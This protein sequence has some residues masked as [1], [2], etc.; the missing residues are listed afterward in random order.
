[1][2]WLI[3]I[4]MFLSAGLYLFFGYRSVAGFIRALAQESRTDLRSVIFRVLSVAAL[5]LHF[6]SY[7]LY[8][9]F[10]AFKFIPAEFLWDRWFSL[11][12][13]AIIGLP[14]AVIWIR[15]MIDAGPESIALKDRRASARGIYQRIRHPQAL[16]KMALPLVVALMLNSPFLALFSLLWI[17]AFYLLCRI[18]EKG[19]ELQLGEEYLN[20]QGATGF[21]VPR[22]AAI[23]QAL[24]ENCLNCGALLH[25]KYCH[26]CGQKNTDINV[27]FRELL[28]EF[29]W[30]EL[31]IDSRFV[32]T[33]VPLIIRP[34]FL[35]ADYV[36]GKRMRYV[37]P[38]RTYVIIS[39]VLFLLLAMTSR[40]SHLEGLQ[41]E[42]EARSEIKAV[43]TAP[44]PLAGPDTAAALEDTLSFDH[45]F[46]Q[47]VEKGYRRGTD[48]PELFV[49]TL[50]ERFAQ[51]MFLLMP[52]FALL[53]KMLYIRSGRY[54]MQHLIFSIHFHAFVFLTILVITATRFLHIPVLSQWLSLLI[55]TIPLYLYLSLKRFYRQGFW[56]TFIKLNLLSISY[57]AIFTVFIA[58]ILLSWLV[59]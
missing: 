52:L 29:L 24:P 17:P 46:T 49:E 28:H 32:H 53:L 1:M 14:A 22:R 59:L 30:D 19:L 33:L 54:Y 10:P 31:R 45:R 58:M 3:V 4:T 12:A 36:A 55:M 5:V 16:G 21:F 43:E 44:Q 18:E 27:P 9:A 25:G 38:L 47:M 11:A 13:A 51:G 6:F 50:I 8:K 48:N 26:D 40:R 20:Y 34:G 15:G 35:T 56:P 41:D 39:F 42:P 37:P 57:G 7:L 2:S 23:R